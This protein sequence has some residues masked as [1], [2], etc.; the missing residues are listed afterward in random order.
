VLSSWRQDTDVVDKSVD[1]LRG[2]VAV[3]EVDSKSS[4]MGREKLGI[5]LTIRVHVLGHNGTRDWV[6]IA[7]QFL[8]Q[9]CRERRL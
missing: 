3:A 7:L 6:G 5:E 9:R 4:Q 1:L 2:S 8:Q